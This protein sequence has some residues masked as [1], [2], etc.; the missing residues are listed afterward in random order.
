MGKL[1]FILGPSGSGKTTK[2]YEE[3]LERAK[4]DTTRNFLVIVP[5]QFTM[6]TQRELAARSESGGILNIDVLSFGRLS[7][8]IMTEVGWKELPV[9]DDT[10]KCLVLQRVAGRITDKLPVLGRRM[11]RQGYIHEVKSIISEFMQYGLSPEDIGKV[12]DA[13]GGNGAL[14]SKLKDLQLIYTS[15]MDYI[16]DSYITREEKLDILREVMPHSK[17]LPDSVVVFDGFTG[18]TPIQLGV[19][20]DIMEIADETIFT[21]LLGEGEKIDSCSD[22]QNLFHMSG[23]TYEALI[24]RAQQGKAA[25]SEP[26]YCHDSHRA[27]EIDFIEKNLFRSSGKIY[28]TDQEPA[29]RM[30]RAS[31]VLEEVHQAGL[32]IYRL[33]EN[34]DELQFRDIALVSGDLES[35]AP[36]FEREFS[37]MGIPYYIDRT[38]AIRLN[39][40]IEGVR[41]AIE[42][43]TKRFSPESVL[44]YLRSGISGIAPERTD[45]LELYVRQ[46][47]IRGYKAW[48]NRFARK[49]EDMDP[50]DEGQLEELNKVREEMMKGL[51]VLGRDEGEKGKILRDNTVLKTS[52]FVNRLY[53]FLKEIGA[54]ETLCGFAASFRE[55]GDLVREKEYDGIYGKLME[56]LEQVESLMGEDEIS[57]GEFG[58][59][60]DAGF[61]EIRIGTIPRTVDKVLIGDIER[62]RVPNVKI[63]FL[64]GAND[65][66]I[67]KNTDKGGLISDLE[68]E[69]LYA[70][71][72]ELAPTPRE[73][74]YNQRLYLYMNLT[75]PIRK[76]YV[77]WALLD[78]SGKSLRPSYLCEEI[79]S[80][81]GRLKVDIPEKEKKTHQIVTRQEGLRYLGEELRIFAEGT[82]GE[83]DTV[84]TLYSA[85]GAEETVGKRDKLEAA[86]FSRY[87]PQRIE[88]ILAE[89]LYCDST[90]PG[91]DEALTLRSSV[92]QLETYAVCP[93][94]FF[95]TYGMKLKESTG[96]DIDNRDTGNV[97]HA[98]ME[99]FSEKLKADGI[100]WREFT[101]GYAAGVVKEILQSVTDTYGASVFQDT[102]RNRQSIKRLEKALLASVLSV[103]YQIK[104]GSFEPGAFEVPFR[105][106]IDME[107]GESGRK[108]RLRLRGKIDR[109]DLA[110]KNGSVYVRV[111]DYKS[112]EKKFDPT[113]MVDGRQLQLPLYLRQ[114]VETINRGGK[115]GV[116]SG[117]L[118]YHLDSP[119]IEA[120]PGE[121]PEAIEKLFRKKE[122]MNGYTKNDP[123]ILVLN[124]ASL[125]GG[126]SDVINVSIKKDG[127]CSSASD[128]L[129]PADFETVMDYSGYVA[130][131]R[132]GE[133][134]DGNIQIHP[135]AKGSCEYCAFL[136]SCGF[137]RKIPG[138]GKRSAAKVKKDEMIPTMRE[139]MKNGSS[140]E[141]TENVDNEGNDEKSRQQESR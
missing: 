99:R 23:K 59:I 100:S 42:V 103:R 40:L 35:Y 126:N 10:G 107:P 56:L 45:R 20:G 106:D 6:Q 76:L 32:E 26:E 124:D 131:K 85:Y 133:I 94:K 136:S 66:N 81:L 139:I 31:T 134:L 132:A 121:S 30:F 135:A 112:S 2:V 111:V 68:R 57:F 141:I 125:E 101:D 102:A 122:R 29:V 127:D 108:R 110:E 53:D 64:L 17:I 58:E 78:V 72:Y 71:G 5:D 120:D 119:I 9:L 73:E 117:M 123:D 8:R 115:N 89:K 113:D 69:D 15:F 105:Q 16:R 37:G 128:V 43:F 118:Y 93:Y 1:R 22:M 49:T 28:K 116:A 14:A 97:F 27:P 84:Y 109:V 25:V 140:K 74:M 114:E 86:A 46:T 60:L 70:K 3:V 75:K 47:G 34:D 41:S 11:G 98:V 61:G 87:S 12:T 36:Y 79:S 48:S 77:S 62:T 63:M 54:F 83:D 44:R 65:G 39:P 19:I 55:E 138:Y 137:D 7:H 21:L 50:E 33:L 88:R 13:V 4:T 130:V 82:S 38:S 18:F 80:M 24:K 129:N 92:S 104:K 52:V 96:Y 67:P 51:C 91:D 95:L 90:A